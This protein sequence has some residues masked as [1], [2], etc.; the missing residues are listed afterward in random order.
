MCREDLCQSPPPGIERVNMAGE[1]EGEDD[2]EEDGHNKCAHHEQLPVGRPNGGYGGHRRPGAECS[3]VHRVQAAVRP[4]SNL[5]ALLR[6]ALA[7]VGEV[8]H[9]L[10]RALLEVGEWAAH[11]HLEGSH[12]W[13]DL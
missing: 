7:A 8:K 11:M 12:T 9:V 2:K 5:V 3:P 6:D 13:L 4:L 10:G 1:A